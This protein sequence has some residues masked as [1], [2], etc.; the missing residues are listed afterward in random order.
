M[1]RADYIKTL[2]AEYAQRQ[3][4][5]RADADR[6]LREAESRDPGIGDCRMRASVIALQ[7]MRQMMNTPD[8]AQRIQIAEKM[9]LDGVENNRELR[10]RLAALGYPADYLEEK[11]RCPKCRDTGYTDDLPAKFCEC[12]EQEL[13]IRMFED[14]TMAGL[15]EQNF[16]SFSED[17]IRSANT[18]EDADRIVGAYL[19]CKRYADQYPDCGKPNLVLHGSVGVGKTFLLNCIFARLLDRGYSGVRITAYRM[20][21]IMRK[22]H[23]G[24]ETDGEDFEALLETPV[25]LI[26]DLGTENML[27]N[28]TIEYLFTLINERCAAKKHTIIAT[29]LS[30]DE[31]Q[32]RYGERVSSRM[33]SQ[34]Y[35]TKIQ[36][37]GVD[38]RRPMN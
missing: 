31:L 38:L 25:L 13:R 1:D 20:N 18:K 21:E 9:R 26:D 32:Q 4:Q 16:E 14:R 28:V 3:A 5:N 7:A 29:N 24:S 10:E 35:C 15:D 12:F 23:I 33:L 27:R 30:K 11:Y 6:R 36:M 2:L 34:Q 37:N 8:A 17:L 19:F 22:K